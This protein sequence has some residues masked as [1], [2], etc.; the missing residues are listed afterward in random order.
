MKRKEII[1]ITTLFC[2]LVSLCIFQNLTSH[3]SIITGR[4]FSA[5]GYNDAL[6]TTR[7]DDAVG[8]SNTK[9]VVDA[10]NIIVGRNLAR[11]Q[12]LD[13]SNT[14]STRSSAVVTDAAAP[15]LPEHAYDMYIRQHN[16]PLYIDHLHKSRERWA[17]KRKNQSDWTQ[18][19]IDDKWGFYVFVKSLGFNVPKIMF[20]TALGPSKL[21]DFVPPDDGSG[22]VIKPQWGG[23]SLGVF[24]LQS[25]FDAR[26]EL[27]G[28]QMSRV[29]VVEKLR[30]YSKQHPHQNFDYLHIEEVMV[31]KQGG[32]KGPPTDYKVF[33]ANGSV[34]SVSIIFN[35]G[36][37][38][39]CVGIVDG[40]FNRMDEHG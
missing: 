31:G 40:D 8:S 26:E 27:S 6:P 15:D 7:R 13:S 1:A 25:G 3:E 11:Q 39:H 37:A 30:S 28:N 22:F 21:Y 34:I 10:T 35:R 16:C 12:I 20:C 4:Y 2:A 38:N 23:L 32:Q 33:V 19:T 17:R 14:S 29:N 24:V 5:D 18:L 9:A 36:S